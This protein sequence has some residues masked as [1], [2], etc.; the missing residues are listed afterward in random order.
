MSAEAD[1][2]DRLVEQAD[3]EVVARAVDDP[4]D[5]EVAGRVVRDLDQ[6]RLDDDLGAAHVEPVDDR[7]QRAHG[8]RRRGDDERVRFGLRP[9]RDRLVDRARRGRSLRGSR[10]AL[11]G[12]CG[13]LCS[14]SLA[15][16]FSASA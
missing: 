13:P 15:A 7:H 16:S 3:Q 11:G 14:F 4:V 9:D 12:D 5:A 2:G 6:H 1:A 8:L 10:S